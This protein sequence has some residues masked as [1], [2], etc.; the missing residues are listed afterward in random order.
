M[1]SNGSGFNT[2]PTFKTVGGGYLG[3]ITGFL[4][5]VGGSGYIHAPTLKKWRRRLWIFSNCHYWKC[6]HLINFH[7]NSSSLI[8]LLA[9]NWCLQEEQA[10][11][12]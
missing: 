3:T 7:N 4:A 6:W 1:V 11:E 12:H 8:M 10:V 9:I 5:L 2:L